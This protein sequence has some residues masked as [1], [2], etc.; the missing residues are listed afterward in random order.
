MAR[1]QV[2]RHAVTRA[3]DRAG[4]AKADHG[5]DQAHDEGRPDRVRPY[6]G[7]PG[8][9]RRA[10]RALAQQAR[11]DSAQR[12]VDPAP[13]RIRRSTGCCPAPRPPE[14]RRPARRSTP[15]AA[16]AARCPGPVPRWRK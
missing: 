13:R 14:S 11:E 9:W 4:G 2:S 12:A 1:Q 10:R 6:P 15:G 16:S 7:A 5:Q 8:R 3:V